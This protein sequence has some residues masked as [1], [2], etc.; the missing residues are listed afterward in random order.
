MAGTTLASGSYVLQLSL[1][2]NEKDALASDLHWTLDVA[3]TSDEKD[4]PIMEDDTKKNFL[5][6]QSRPPKT[7]ELLQMHQY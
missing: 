7:W 5:Q 4:C 6:V 1:D 3:P 2:P